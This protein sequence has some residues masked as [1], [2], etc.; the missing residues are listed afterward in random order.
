MHLQL[1]SREPLLHR[2]PD[3]FRLL[4]GSTV[5]ENI[6]CISLER[7]LGEPLLHPGIERQMQEDIREQRGG[8]ETGTTP[9]VAIAMRH[10]RGCDDG[11]H[12]PT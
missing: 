12:L 11:D 2:L 4:L 3:P 1:A 9:R 7:H 5:H 10:L 8:D 6:V